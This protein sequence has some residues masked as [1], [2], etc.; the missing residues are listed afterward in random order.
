[1]EPK[2]GSALAGLAISSRSA[3]PRG[4]WSLRIRGSGQT[5]DGPEM[6][7]RQKPLVS[8]D[9]VMIARFE[10]S[11]RKFRTI[12]ASHSIDLIGLAAT[13]ADVDDLFTQVQ[14]TIRYLFI[15][16]A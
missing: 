12:A 14:S 7:E 15:K 16:H 1:M 8:G 10:P 2:A 13:A 4:Q 6:K 9:V 5:Y 3:G 11:E